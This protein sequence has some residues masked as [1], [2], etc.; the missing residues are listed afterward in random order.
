MLS[1]AIA[2]K[3]PNWA[4]DLLG[5]SRGYQFLYLIQTGVD[6]IEKVIIDLLFTRTMSNN[7][8]KSQLL[9]VALACDGSQ[10]VQ[11]PPQQY[12]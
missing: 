10:V 11:A 9:N 12:P 8:H 3:D 4:R 7:A 6:L 5:F 1:C 2:L